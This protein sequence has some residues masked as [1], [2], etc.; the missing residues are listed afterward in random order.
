MPLQQLHDRGVRLAL[1]DFGTGYASLNCLTRFPLAR[2]KIDRHFVTHIT[3]DGEDAAIVR[4]LMTMAHNLGLGVIAEGVETVEQAAFLAN[5]KC[6][7]AQG[8][9]YAKP[10][11]AEEFEAYLK[12]SHLA[13]AGSRPELRRVRHTGAQPRALKS[14]GRRRYPGA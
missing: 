10:L 7:E 5:E 12:A 13:S 14:G 6:E 2:I 4:S 11:P 8:F 3:D 9:L 1:D